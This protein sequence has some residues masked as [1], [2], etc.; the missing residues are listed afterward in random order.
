MAGISFAS[1]PFS[2]T[3]LKF[4]GV[5]LFIPVSIIL[6]MIGFAVYSFGYSEGIVRVASM[7]IQTC[8][9]HEDRQFVDTG[10]LF[11]SGSG[12]LSVRNVCVEWIV[13]R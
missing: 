3:R 1:T 5:L 11:F 6:T 9:K 8:T 12:E 13:R 2:P 7:D 4:I 10:F